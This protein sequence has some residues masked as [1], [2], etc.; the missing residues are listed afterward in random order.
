[1]CL[2]PRIYRPAVCELQTDICKLRRSAYLL[3]K[4][5]S[6]ILPR[7]LSILRPEGAFSRNKYF[8][9][10]ARVIVV[11]AI[12]SSRASFFFFPSSDSA[13]DYVSGNRKTK[14][15]DGDGDGD[16]D[17]GGGVLGSNATNFS[18]GRRRRDR[19]MDESR[20]NRASFGKYR[21]IKSR[22]A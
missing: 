14:G 13:S 12:E 2:L 11:N 1:M 10:R 5:A 22:R 8:V 16:N 6:S 21:A 20:K 15:D 3:A 9:D 18:R 19:R 7:R 4:S 17:D